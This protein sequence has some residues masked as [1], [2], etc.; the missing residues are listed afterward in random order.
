MTTSTNRTA[1]VTGGTI[2]IGKEVARLLLCEGTSV[3]IVGRRQNLVD[4]AVAELTGS[5]AGGAEIIGFAA[6]VSVAQDLDRIV[7]S[8]VDRWGRIDVLINNAGIYDDAS[9]Q[10]ISPE[11]WNDVLAVNLTAPFLLSQR[12]SRVMAERD[13]GAI[14]NIASV[15][16]HGVDGTYVAYN[17]SKAAVLHLTKQ[18]AVEL[19]PWGIRCNSVSPGWTRTP[20]VESVL[21]GDQLEALSTGWKRAPLNRMV[22]PV[23]VAETVVFLAGDKASGITGTD[24]VVDG[25]VIANLWIVETLPE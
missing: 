15:D 16:G 20:M 10:T 2:G 1:I 25:G 8:A 11:M 9:F 14:V 13:T 6:D 3:L 22:T 18:A 7:D 5:A 12:V 4:A 23:E 24:V 19:G 17:V 21:S